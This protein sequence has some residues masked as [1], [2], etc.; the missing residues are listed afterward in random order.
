VT[1]AVKSKV[2]L[3]LAIAFMLVANAHADVTLAAARIGAVDV[4]GVSSTN[5]PLACMRSCGST[6]PI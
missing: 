3:A 1:K 5:R 2:V 4:A 6:C